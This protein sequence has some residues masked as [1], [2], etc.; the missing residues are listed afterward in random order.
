M[1]P[2]I[3]D[4][5]QRKREITLAALEVFADRGFDATSMSQIAEAAGIGKGTLYEYFESKGE[6][7]VAAAVAWV[8]ALEVGIEALVDESQDP[9]TRLRQLC[10]ATMDAF[11]H[12]TSMVKLFFGFIKI[13]FDDPSAFQRYETMQRMSAPMRTAIVDIL[14]DG[15]SQK[16]FRPEIAR[17]AERIAI[18]LFAYLDGLGMHYMLNPDYFDLGEQVE[19]HLE[20]LLTNLRAEP[21]DQGDDHA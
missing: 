19:F 9:E 3:V 18:N 10:G 8:E 15:V 2:K 11:L 13:Y 14:L 5:Q 12:D 4:K 21:I 16:V 17:D 20:V 6:L 7:T 1:S